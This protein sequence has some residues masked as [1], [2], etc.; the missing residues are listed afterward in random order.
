[1][2]EGTG[3]QWYDFRKDSIKISGNLRH[4]FLI[5]QGDG[6]GIGH[7]LKPNYIFGDM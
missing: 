6:S 4:N 7:L 1:M 3:P 2:P 5:A